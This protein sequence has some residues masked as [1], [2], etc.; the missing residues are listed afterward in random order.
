MPSD[1]DHHRAKDHLIYGQRDGAGSQ[2]RRINAEGGSG[3]A[4]RVSAFSTGR[5]AVQ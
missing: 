5:Q 2:H 4:L 3:H 1:L